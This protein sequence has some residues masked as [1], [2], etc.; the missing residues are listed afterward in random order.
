MRVRIKVEG[1]EGHWDVDI[2]EEHEFIK[3][4]CEKRDEG[5]AIGWD[6]VAAFEGAIRDCITD[7]MTVDI[8][9]NKEVTGR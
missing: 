2:P 7:E 6:A 3:W 8:I 4:A 1:L 5:G 9:P